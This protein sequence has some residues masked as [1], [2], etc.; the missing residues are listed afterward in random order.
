MSSRH[1]VRFILS[2][3]LFVHEMISSSY[4]VMPIRLDTFYRIVGVKTKLFQDLLIDRVVER[5]K[6]LLW[7]QTFRS[8]VFKLL[9]PRMCSDL[10]NRVTLA[11]VNLQYFTYKMSAIGGKKLGYFVISGQNFFV[12]I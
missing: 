12:K 11:R 3:S 8:L 10:F 7:E 2:L 5:H 1:H 9:K 6:L 4:V